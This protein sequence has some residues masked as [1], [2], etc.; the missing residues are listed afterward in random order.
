MTTHSRSTMCQY[1]APV[2]TTQ[3][4]VGGPGAELASQVAEDE[5]PEQDVEQV[6]ARQ[7]EIEHEEF[8]VGKVNP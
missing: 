3:I 8:V 1:V 4:R 5:Q 7:H 2:S 6:N